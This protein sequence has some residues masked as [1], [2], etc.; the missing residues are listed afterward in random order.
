MTAKVIMCKCKFKYSYAYTYVGTVYVF[1]R[2][3]WDANA[4]FYSVY[5]YVSKVKHEASFARIV[6]SWVPPLSIQ[7]EKKKTSITTN[8]QIKN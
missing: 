4:K 7:F 5:E 1:Y 3:K 6:C 8:S 2:V